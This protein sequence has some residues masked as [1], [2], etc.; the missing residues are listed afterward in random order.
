MVWRAPK[1]G[2]SLVE[3]PKPPGRVG[4]EVRGTVNSNMEYIHPIHRQE[5]INSQQ[6]GGLVKGGT[7][8]LTPSH[9]VL[10]I[11]V[12]YCCLFRVLSNDMLN[13][14]IGTFS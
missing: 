8:G 1:A 10:V 6:W 14:S 12:P 13:V 11:L 4:P 2:S 5:K 3:E 7:R 9:I